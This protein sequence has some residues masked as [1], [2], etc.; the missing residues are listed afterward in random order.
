MALAY[1]VQGALRPSQIVTWLRSDDS[2][3]DLTGATLTGT[4]RNSAGVVRAITGTLSV[5]T[6]ASGIFTWA[7]SAADVTSAGNFTVQFSA[8]FGS[9][10]TPARTLMAKWVVHEQLVVSA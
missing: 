9:S 3:E 4:I 2:P 8:A 7:Y 5:T 6:A 1:A 10:P